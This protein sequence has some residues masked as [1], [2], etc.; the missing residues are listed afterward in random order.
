MVKTRKYFIIVIMISVFIICFL[1]GRAIALKADGEK[2]TESDIYKGAVPIPQQEDTLSAAKEQKNVEK[3]TQETTKEIS[4]TPPQK[5]Y[6]PCGTEVL[7][8]YSQTAVYSKTMGDWRAHTGIDYLGKEREYVKSV[9]D[10]VVSSVYRDKLWGNCVEII[11]SGNLIGKYKNLHEEI[12]VKIGDKVTGGQAIGKIGSSASIE[13]NEE[14]HLHF[15]LWFEGVP[16][17]PS[18]YIY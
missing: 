4:E 1:I 14:P 8:D 6:Y 17:N 15:E 16:I 2:N 13:R 18:S 11:H 10:G 12:N 5:M 7:N 3:N 9:W